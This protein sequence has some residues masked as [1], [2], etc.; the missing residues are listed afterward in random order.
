MVLGLSILFSTGRGCVLQGGAS[1]CQV[2]LGLH[3]RETECIEEGPLD[4]LGYLASLVVSG[5]KFESLGANLQTRV[6][7]R[8]QI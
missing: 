4:R 8:K 6:I 5:L 7:V 3:T 1:S 2:S